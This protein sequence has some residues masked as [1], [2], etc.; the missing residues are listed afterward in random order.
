M[1]AQRMY[2]PTFHHKNSFFNQF[3]DWKKKMEKFCDHC[4]AGGHTIYQ[5]FKF[6]GYPEWYKG[7]KAEK[8][9]ATHNNYKIAANVHTDYGDST[10]Y[11]SSKY[12]KVKAWSPL[13]LNYS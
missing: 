13:I 8:N 10:A 3:K 6:I 2:K 1:V 4:K 9:G 11:I 12:V 5:C 7:V